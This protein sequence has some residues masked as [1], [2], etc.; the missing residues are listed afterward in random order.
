MLSGFASGTNSRRR[1]E[2]LKALHLHGSRVAPSRETPLTKL[3][4]GMADAGF[5]YPLP[6]I[7]HPSSPNYQPLANA[8]IC[9]CHK[10]LA[11][12]GVT[13]FTSKDADFNHTA[14]VTS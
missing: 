12:Q 2:R 7:R 5:G 10:G 14:T 9:L 11:D 1:L 13:K 8:E 6:M 3:T 4:Y